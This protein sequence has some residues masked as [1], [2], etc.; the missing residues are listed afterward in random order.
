MGTIAGMTGEQERMSRQV[1]R[2][3]L[4]VAKPP[5]PWPPAPGLNDSRLV[6]LAARTALDVL[7]QSRVGAFVNILYRSSRYTSRGAGSRQMS[8]PDMA[9]ESRGEN[10]RSLV[11]AC[12]DAAERLSAEER[13]AVRARGQLPAWFVPTVAREARLIR[14]RW[15]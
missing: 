11:R 2:A 3:C 14:Q 7:A 1:R 10:M 5:T 9:K 12:E 4:K 13:A 8:I 6:F 15:Q